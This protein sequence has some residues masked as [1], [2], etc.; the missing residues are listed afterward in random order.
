[1]RRGLG[2]RGGWRLPGKAVS[3]QLWGFGLPSL[4]EAHRSYDGAS[5]HGVLH[6]VSLSLSCPQLFSASSMFYMYWVML[7]RMSAMTRVTMYADSLTV[8]SQG[9]QMHTSVG[10][11]HREPHVLCVCVC[12]GTVGGLTCGV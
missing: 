2:E 12:S 11:P 5:H 10:L 4:T 3:A 9:L 1:M 6:S 8:R 7:G